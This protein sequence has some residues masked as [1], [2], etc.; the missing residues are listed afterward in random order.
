MLRLPFPAR[1][2][3]AVALS[4]ILF[5]CCVAGMWRAVESCRSRLSVVRSVG[6]FALT[7]AV[8]VTW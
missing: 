6:A 8:L 5:G 1:M 3:D 7:F 2:A 4:A